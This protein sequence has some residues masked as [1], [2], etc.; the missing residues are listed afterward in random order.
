MDA[1]EWTLDP[2]LSQKF[3]E[4]FGKSNIDHF[5]TRINKQ[6]NSYLFWHPEPEAVAKNTLSYR[7]Q[8]SFLH[9]FTFQFLGW[10]LA[11]I[12]REKTNA[13]TVVSDL[14]TQYC[15]PQLL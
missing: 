11:K 14:P 15:Y 9:I 12:H 2:V 3:V 6:L 10:V 5:A 8:Q 4:N 13:V 7:E 1:T